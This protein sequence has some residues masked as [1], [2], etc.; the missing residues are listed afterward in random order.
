MKSLIT[1]IIG[2]FAV[3][4]AYAQEEAI[5]DG[6]AITFEESSFDF[7]DIHQDDIRL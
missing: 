6:P 4:C 1:M 7:G 2:V 5:A 3:F